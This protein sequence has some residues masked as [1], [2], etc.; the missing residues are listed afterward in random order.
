MRK[1]RDPELI[2][3]L[4]QIDVAPLHTSA[5]RITRGGRN[6]MVA[7]SPKGRWDDGSFPVLY[8]ALE[9]DV[10]RAELY[11][12]L[13]R[14]QPVYPSALQLHLHELSVTAERAISIIEPPRLLEL[15]ID[16]QRYGSMDFAH[17]QAEY[18][19][20]Q[21]IGEVSN[22]LGVD[23]IIVPSARAPGHNLVIL[24][25]NLGEN[26]IQHVRDHGPQDLRRW[27]TNH[28]KL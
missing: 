18:S 23:A 3:K 7:T 17:L 19:Q 27:A 6:P 28:G 9:A 4:Q 14:G 21:K 15:G 24:T 20:T 12:H 22:F 2:E 5:W 8:T 11:W 1:I 16:L 13:T 25:G 26:G 10:A